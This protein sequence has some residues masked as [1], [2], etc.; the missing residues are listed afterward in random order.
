VKVDKKGLRAVVLLVGAAAVFIGSFQLFGLRIN[1]TASH[2]SAGLWH[3]V[4]AVEIA[5]GDVVTYDIEELYELRP[6]L[7]ETRMVFPS[8][9][10]MKK[11]AALPGA[12]VEI[13][14]D[15]VA[16]DGVLF[17]DAIFAD[18]SWRKVKYP[19]IVPRGE[20]W[21][22]AN[23]RAAYDSRYHGPVPLRLIKEKAEPVLLWR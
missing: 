15:A 11:V 17:P 12:V 7:R 14:G 19:L 6:D 1:L 3:V 4:P 9:I 5:I 21:I 16:V 10:L 18:D 20:V 22:M 13:S 23:S 8:N 2:V